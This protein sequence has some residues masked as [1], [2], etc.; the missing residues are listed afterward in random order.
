M[1]ISDGGYGSF[2]KFVDIDPQG[3][4]VPAIWGLKIKIPGFF[5]ADMVQT[6]LQAFWSRQ[7]NIPGDTG[8]G[9]LYQTILRNIK[10]GERAEQSPFIRQIR[11]VMHKVGSQELSIKFFMD[12]YHM[13]HR[14]K[15]FTQGRFI[16][17]LGVSGPKAPSVA[18]WGRCMVSNFIKQANAAPFIIDKVHK[19]LII[20][21][22]NSVPLDN[23]GL[24]MKANGKTWNV[25]YPRRQLHNISCS[26]EIEV[27]G[28]VN[29]EDS[30]WF[31]KL[32]GI[33]WFPLTKKQID[34]LE[35]TP[36]LFVMVSIKQ[37]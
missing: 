11:Q 35:N 22:E 20:D 2:A 12:L 25:A 6:P 24:P 18:T 17:S 32:A 30:Y 7:A 36:L 5:E 1:S 26:T 29:L 28:S 33:K 10:W 37:L 14:K 23:H 9:G 27:I 13:R 15:E 34:D 21:F 19:R 16:G 4:V 3:Q 8:K 31:E